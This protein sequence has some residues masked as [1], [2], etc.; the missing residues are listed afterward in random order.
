ML[1]L[2]ALAGVLA[3]GV[4]PGLIVTAALSLLLVIQRISR[5]PVVALARDPETG[6]WARAEHHRDWAPAEGVL[7]VRVEGGLFYANAV[8]VKEHMLELV[9]SAVPDVLVL[10]MGRIFDLDVETLDA[11]AELRAA[12]DERGVEVRLA[13]VRSGA[14]RML[15]RARIDVATLPTLDAAVGLER[16]P[17]Q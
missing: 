7:V 16:T 17:A 8:A 6:E 14:E 10:D 11:F 5:P 1:A 15:E 13:E 3:L 2:L 4:L 12:L 9:R